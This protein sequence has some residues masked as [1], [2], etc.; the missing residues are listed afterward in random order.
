MIKRGLFLIALTTL[1]FACGGGDSDGGGD[2]GGTGTP[3]DTFNRGALLINAADNIIIPALEDFQDHVDDLSEKVDA[4]TASSTIT[5]LEEVQ[6]SF[7]ETYKVWQYVEMFNIGKAE[8]TLF[9]NKLNIYPTSVDEIEANISS[10][11]YDLSHPNNF[12]AQGLPALDYLLFGVAADNSAIVDLYAN[13]TNASKY[14]TYLEDIVDTISSLTDAVVNDWNGT[15]RDS[16]VSDTSNTTVSSFN[17]LVND[18]VY[19]YEKGFRANKIGIPA[20]VW[21]DVLPENVEAYHKGDISIEL[22]SEALNAIEEFFNGEA[23]GSTSEGA[24]FKTYLEHLDRDDLVTAITNQ[25]A[26]ARAELTGLDADLAQQLEDNK[27][28]VLETYNEIQ[29]ATAYLKAD[30]LSAFNV[31]VDYVDADGD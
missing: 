13:D 16:F 24:S 26:S 2:D 7:V 18:F 14:Q 21:G 22:A 25:I 30:M 11:S 10:G 6:E 9:T 19:Y 1:F 31:S 12:N 15:Y 17:L 5:T 20:G 27:T 23:Y 28:P 29:T 3:T 8:S 4:F